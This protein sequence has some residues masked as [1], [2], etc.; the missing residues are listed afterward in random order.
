MKKVTN[1]IR[2]TFK[3]LS[4]RRYIL[5]EEAVRF[6]PA[7][8]ETVPEKPTYITARS[9][10]Y[11]RVVASTA[12]GVEPGQVTLEAHNG[13]IPGDATHIEQLEEI[14]TDRSVLP[15]E[16]QKCRRGQKTSKRSGKSKK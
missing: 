13:P 16:L 15:K 3:V 9:W 7:S 11:A 14:V 2:K 4:Y 10:F 6:V 1:V 8:T 12:F 5:D